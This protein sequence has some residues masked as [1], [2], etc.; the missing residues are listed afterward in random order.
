MQT[1]IYNAVLVLPETLLE[2]GWLLIEDGLITALG[3]GAS[4]PQPQTI[5]RPV[6]AE[7]NFVLPGMIDLHCDG[8]EKL[9]MP[10]P[11]VMFDIN[12]ALDENDRRLAACGITTEFHAVSLDDSEFGV[13]STD[14]VGELSKAIKNTPDLLVRHE[15]HARFEVTSVRGFEVVTQM[16]KDGEV[17]LVS[18]M[19]HSPGQ[20]QYKTEQSFRDYL[21]GT[22]HSTDD[23]I[24]QLL[25]WK[26][27]Q[28]ANIPGRI[29][30]VTRLA[31]ERGLAIA[32]HD[33]DS[34]SKVEQWPALGVTISEFP[35][36]IEAASRAHE[37]GLAVCMGAPNVL[38]GKSSGGNLSALEAIQAGI[39]NVLCSDYYPAAFL[40]TVFK[41]A[42]QKI[43]TLPEAT[44]LVT[45]N[46]A[47]AVGLGK[48]YGS[49]EAGKVADVVI[50]KLRENL[51]RVRQLFVN[52]EEHLRLK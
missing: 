4:C 10:R 32:T 18:I 46:P 29:E 34:A 6:N 15:M 24:D 51:P 37:L 8:I 21:K 22:V 14:F 40:A 47:L 44:R 41:L 9:V 1:L 50:V 3:E 39:T 38:R 48:Q 2:N 26:R 43:L 25:I 36:T 20:G 52:G 13:R 23:E 33:D 35:T 11:N 16:I 7:G 31:R 12:V 28:T 27:S 45:L 49:L 42:S 30:I 19:D 17:R 5:A